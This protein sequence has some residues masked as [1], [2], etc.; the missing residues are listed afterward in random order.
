M[1]VNFLLKTTLGLFMLVLIVACKNSTE[2]SS[3]YDTFRNPSA[4]VRPMV[5]WWWNGNCV[6][7]DEI[8]RELHIMKNA[9]IGG[10]EINS[11][12]M[13]P[14][15]RKTDIK[16]LMWA[17]P[18][19]C[20]MVKTASQEAKSL[21]MITDLIVG[22]GWPF[23]G[24]FLNDDETIQRLGLEMVS[25]KANSTINLDLSDLLPAGKTVEIISVK[26]IPV[27]LN[28]LEE[29]T[30]ISAEIK[31][32][33]LIYKSDDKDY[34]LVI[35]FKERNYRTVTNGSPGAD[36]PIMDHYNK[37][38]IL[39][40]LNR[41]KALEKET[42]LSLSELIRALF[43]DS[44]E[45]DKA[46]WTDDMNEQFLARLGYD[47]SPYLPFI[48]Q[49]QYQLYSFSISPKLEE[50]IKRVRYDFSSILITVFLERFTTEFQ[51]FCTENNVICRYQ[52]YGT[53]WYMGLFQGNMIPDIPE[54][55]NWIYSRGRNEADPPYYTWQQQH[56]YM[57]WNKAASSGA[58]L[59]GKRITSCEAMTNTAGVFRTSLETVK[60]SD[61]MNF[62]TGINQ[63]VLHGFN[64]S[65]PEAGF[66]GWMRYGTYFSEQN[67]W[68]PYFKNWAEYNAR[69]SSV[70][71]NSKPQ[72]DIAILGKVRDLWAEDGLKRAALNMTP[73]Y[74]ARMWE[75]ISNLGSYC[76]YIH[77][78]IL[79]TAK[80]EGNVLV[81]GEM[82][83]RSIFLTEVESLLPDAARKLL[84]F[85]QAGGNIV[86]IGK[87]VQR[88]PSYKNAAENDQVVNKIM[89]QLH[90]SE[91]V[92]FIDAPENSEVFLTWTKDM[93]QKTGLET[94]VQISNPVHYLYSMKQTDGERE[95][96]FFVNSHRK[97]S[98]EFD[99]VFNTGSKTPYLWD[100]A[101]GERFALPCQ[102]KNKLHIRI[103]A[104]ES[105]LIVYEPVKL[106][107]PVYAFRSI[108]SHSEPLK[109][110]WKVEFN[111]INGKEFSRSFEKLIDF[112]VSEDEEIR[113][114]AGTAVYS[115]SLENDG[116]IRYIQLSEVNQAVTELYI[117]DKHVGT[118]WYGNHC[119]D[120]QD[121]LQPGKNE[122]KIKLTTTL[123]NYCMSLEDNPTA[124][125]WARRYRRPFP[126]GLQEVTVL[127]NH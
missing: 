96:Y 126:A 64:Y 48:L 78:P 71:Q 63:T 36:G 127:R 30:D 117:N 121:F 81:C 13:P 111:H 29:I 40:Y 80:V 100:P 17:G 106:D 75:A 88:S 21:G 25:V 62:I 102:Q 76:D 27:Q 14:A 57:L 54:S 91:N 34:E 16:A 110:E 32:N 35:V 33:R 109:T 58:H 45:L 105:A 86:F 56:G 94:Q 52:A 97:K 12:A 69:L 1:K 85:A 7:A 41:L 66:P 24:K 10:V 42:G 18:E 84:E 73:W 4:D 104:L 120:V 20:N 2:E 114:F 90:Q 77:Q 113:T 31:N 8:K 125:Q 103:D 11:I 60:Q 124:M 28:S 38:A 87:E 98:V 15:A 59:T 37:E 51:N 79:E 26:L 39:G 44:I 108:P 118:K 119:Y 23:G 122:M 95:I 72:A 46:N 6:E 49:D 123:A 22:S 101:T 19:W 55:N 43:C 107:L 68:W 92:F 99:A 83:Y 50:T 70:F 67:T 47:V 116:K 9:G 93:F 112:S 5:R 89:D 3:L 53:P 82:N 65:P 61:D 115:C 74:Y